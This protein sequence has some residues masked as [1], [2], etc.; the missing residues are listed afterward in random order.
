MKD[1]LKPPMGLDKVAAPHLTPP[2][3]NCSRA[4]FLQAVDNP[5]E[6]L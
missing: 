6:K 4:F 3:A 1:E 2:P 5:V